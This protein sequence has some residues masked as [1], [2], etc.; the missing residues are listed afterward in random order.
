M[1]DIGTGHV[2]GNQ[3]GVRIVRADGW[4]EHG[5]AASGA[6]YLEIAWTYCESSTYEKQEEKKVTGD[7]SH[8]ILSFTFDIFASPLSGKAPKMST[9]N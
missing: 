4:I 2:A 7:V 9:A 8:L 5:P 3:N 1:R 6:D